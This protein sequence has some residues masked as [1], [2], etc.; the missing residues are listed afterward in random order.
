MQRAGAV[1]MRA[2]RSTCTCT[3][4]ARAHIARLPPASGMHAVARCLISSGNYGAA[5]TGEHTL[6]YVCRLTPGSAPFERCRFLCTFRCGSPRRTVCCTSLLILI[7]RLLCVKA[8]LFSSVHLLVCGRHPRLACQSS[9]DFSS[10][11]TTGVECAG[12]IWAVS[13]TNFP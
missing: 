4:I 8:L 11:R 9:A 6:H 2:L 13:P 10:G 5:F 3:S 12:L 7:G 1:C